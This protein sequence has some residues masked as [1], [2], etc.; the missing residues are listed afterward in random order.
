M[1][2]KPLLTTYPAPMQATFLTS[3][4]EGDAMAAPFLTAADVWKS[5]NGSWCPGGRLFTCRRR[6]KNNLNVQASSWECRYRSLF[7]LAGPLEL[8]HLGLRPCG[9]QRFLSLSLPRLALPDRDT[10]ACRRDT[11]GRQV[12][13]FSFSRRMRWRVRLV[14]ASPGSQQTETLCSMAH[15]APPHPTCP[16][17]L[18]GGRDGVSRWYSGL[19]LVLRTRAAAATALWQMACDDEIVLSHA[20][21]ECGILSGS[22]PL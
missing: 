19:A 3:F 7:E 9:K 16:P 17:D 15:D 8:A 20:K 12:A 18:N 22:R 14:L 21:I 13:D 11:T 10:I 2:G 4:G 1:L 5:L 6:G